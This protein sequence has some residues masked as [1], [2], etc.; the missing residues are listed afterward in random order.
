MGALLDQKHFWQGTPLRVAL[1]SWP[2][3][4][5]LGYA[6]SYCTFIFFWVSSGRFEKRG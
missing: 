5:L 4:K 1:L 2:V 6:F 3:G